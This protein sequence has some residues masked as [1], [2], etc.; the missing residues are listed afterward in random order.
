MIFFQKSGKY[1]KILINTER[2]IEYFFE[3]KTFSSLEIG[4]PRLEVALSRL[5]VALSRLEVALSRLE[6]DIPRGE[7]A[8]SKLGMSTS[9]L[10]NAFPKPGM[11]IPRGEYRYFGGE[12]RF[13]RLNFQYSLP[14]RRLDWRFSKKTWNKCPI[15]R[16][17]II[18][19][20]EIIE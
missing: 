14:D 13:S 5:E 2:E 1:A 17:K 7:I 19:I 9:S 18:E 15:R 12:I 6:V 10:D 4:I 11:I 20:K 16:N 8:I 3:T